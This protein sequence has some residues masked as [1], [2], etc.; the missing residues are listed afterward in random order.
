MMEEEVNRYLRYEA[1]FK[2][3]ICLHCQYCLAHNGVEN[4]FRRLHAWIPIEVRKGLV[5]YSKGLTIVDAKA[6]QTPSI[7][8]NAIEGLK[9]IKGIVCNSCGM[10]FGSITTMKNHCWQI[11]GWRTWKGIYCI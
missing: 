2:V 3:L 9:V 8:I 11:H 7:E 10:A 1:E 5:E 6:T 4:H